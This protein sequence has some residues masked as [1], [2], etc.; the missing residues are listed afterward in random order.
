MK[1]NSV[2]RYVIVFLFVFYHP[3][4]AYSLSKTY[5]ENMKQRQAFFFQAGF[6]YI[7]PFLKSIKKFPIKN[8]FL[9]YHF[10]IQYLFS[11]TPC[12]FVSPVLG[13]GADYYQLTSRN[14]VSSNEYFYKLKAEYESYTF[15]PIVGINLKFGTIY[16]IFLLGHYSIYNHSKLN[17]LGNVRYQ[18]NEAS[19]LSKFS[20][21]QQQIWGSE[22]INTIN[23]NNNLAIG[24][25][26]KYQYHELNYS[27][28]IFTLVNETN[29]KQD[30]D[31]TK[32]NFNEYSA[33]LSFIF[34]I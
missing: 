21:A 24:L 1:R 17:I 12:S 9:G 2:L 4:L 25:G 14:V 18:S 16:S 8:P 10:N 13:M 26:L 30:F 5:A 31:Q 23:L 3:V 15:S 20:L 29:F 6:S 11:M 19:L 34:K 32:V 22:L 27:G 7:D 28:T 33:N